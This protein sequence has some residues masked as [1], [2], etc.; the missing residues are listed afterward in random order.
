MTLGVSVSDRQFSGQIQ[1]VLQ[2]LRRAGCT[3]ANTLYILTPAELIAAGLSVHLLKMLSATSVGAVA[4]PAGAGGEPP[5]PP[6]R[7]ITRLLEDKASNDVA[8]KLGFDLFN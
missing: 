1:Q 5:P 2:A 4:V 3:K 8:F 6:P 7:L